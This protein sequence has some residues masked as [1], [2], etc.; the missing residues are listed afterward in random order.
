M[1]SLLSDLVLLESLAARNLLASSDVKLT[2]DD[3]TP[4]NICH[5]GAS[6]AAMVAGESRFGVEA[7]WRPEATED[8]GVDRLDSS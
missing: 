7:G 8:G 5:P 6:L 2:V 4:R 3:L 1:L